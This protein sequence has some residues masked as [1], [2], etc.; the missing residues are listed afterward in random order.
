M[1]ELAEMIRALRGELHQA[2]VDGQG[3]RV[4][5]EL[6]PVEIETTVAV[7]R[8]AGLGGRIRFLVVE[9]NGNGKVASSQTQRIALTLHPKT[10]GPDGT[11]RAALIG[12]DEL[13]GER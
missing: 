1:I 4:R 7:D 2:L 10:I 9:M 13:P 3:D 6:G 5:F 11:P 8:E 12:G